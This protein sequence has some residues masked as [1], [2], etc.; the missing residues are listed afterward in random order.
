MPQLRQLQESLEPSKTD[1]G[2]AISAI[3][4][5]IQMILN[6]CK[7]QKWIKRVILITNGTGRMDPDNV[8]DIATKLAEESIELV[9]L[10]VDFDDHEYGFKEEGKASL[11]KE[12]EALLRDIVDRSEGIYGTLAEAIEELRLPRI[13][14]VRPIVSYRGELTLG[15]RANPELSISIERY[16]KVARRMPPSAHS[17]AVNPD[18]NLTGLRTN[19]S[20]TIIDSDNKQQIPRDE[21]AKGYEYGRTAVHI[22]E[23]EQNI[24]KLETEASYEI[25]GFIPT[26]SFERYLL[27]EASNQIVAQKADLK[28]SLALS[29]LVH[30]LFELE[31]CAIARVV[32]KDMSDPL[33]TLLSPSIEPDFECLYENQLPFA[34]DIR[35]YKFPPLD[36]ILTVSGQ[37]LTQ[38]RNLPSDDL[39]AAM[40]DFVD[41]MKIDLEETFS[42]VVH[43]IEDAIKYRAVHPGLPPIADILLKYS[44]PASIPSQINRLIEVADV[45]KVPP[46]VKGRKRYRETEKPISGLNVEEL[47]KKQKRKID[48]NNAIPEFKQA[49]ANTE[50]LEEVK[51]AVQQM[52][53]IIEDRI[54]HSFA[55]S[56][57]G[58]A[59]E[60][61]GVMRQELIELEEPIMYNDALRR[62]KEKITS[63]ELG[64]NRS[65]MW[66]RIRSNRMGL[67]DT[68]I[69]PASD[70]APEQVDEFMRI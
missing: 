68:R 15:D 18:E 46:K 9:V 69:S 51:D 29:S 8:Q 58:R 62:L 12:N 35:S 36:K 14:P 4:V 42:P 13:K 65:D 48:A 37:T 67:I 45:K 2:D 49:L 60:E 1:K 61:L 66:R 38:H 64:G 34:E 30:A 55:D 3:I 10:G 27:I 19:Y 40:S 7:K 47:F 59:L 23:S 22:S 6:F 43:R 26:E 44:T 57:Y 17:Y 33:L 31:C 56:S 21:L 20:Y 25:V 70:V 63:E 16:P 28:A 53:T 41:N 50:S 32:K 39:N 24:T 5:A 11:K 52:S 54:R